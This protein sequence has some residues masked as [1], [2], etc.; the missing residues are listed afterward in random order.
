MRSPEVRRA[1]FDALHSSGC[2][3]LPNA[4]DVGSARMLAGLGFSA[5]AST[6][7]G[8]AWSR[9]LPDGAMARE[10]VLDH[11]RELVAATELP[12]N[13]DFE[14]GYG[15]TPDDVG[16]SVRLAAETGVAGL[17]I[18]DATGDPANRLF[19]IGEAV[20]RLA[21]A[22]EALGG[23][24]VL[25]VGRAEGFIAGH[26]DLDDVIAR[27]QAYSDAGADCLYA[28][29]ITTAE[30]ITAVVGAVA[31]KPVNVLVGA[32]SEFTVADLAA[33]GVRRIS[34]G[35]AFARSAWGGF[36]GAARTLAQDG[37][38]DGLA[39]A[40]RGAELNEFFGSYPDA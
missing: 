19:A 2:F 14:N 34:V 18:E 5:L 36:L 22:R 7:S 32:T 17:S 26:R 21:A 27:L 3:V 37:R 1:A 10:A 24:G 40:T 25:L 39:G 13:A 4:W 11:L 9:G 8:A 23:T 29:G 20:E 28:P 33:L 15:T 12:L 16:H 31:P 35:G 6:S 30:Q 38:F